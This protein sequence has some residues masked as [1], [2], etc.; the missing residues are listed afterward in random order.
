MSTDGCRMTLQPKGF[1]NSKA[2]CE[3]RAVSRGVH[4]PVRVIQV[5]NTSIDHGEG[6]KN[7]YE[8]AG[9]IGI[10]DR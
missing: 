2:S 5:E 6:L 1:V 4:H 9:G 10:C 7:E 3:A 8:Y